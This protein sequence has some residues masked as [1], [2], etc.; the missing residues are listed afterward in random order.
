MYNQYFFPDVFG[1][2]NE[3]G[4]KAIMLERAARFIIESKVTRMCY[5]KSKK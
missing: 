2:V 1:N 3:Y 5:L 4:K